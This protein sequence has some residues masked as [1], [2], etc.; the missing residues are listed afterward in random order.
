MSRTAIKITIIALLLHSGSAIASYADSKIELQAKIDSIL[1]RK[2]LQHASLGIFAVNLA[3]D[4]LITHNSRH[5]FTPASNLKLITTGLAI[6]VLGSD[7]QFPTTLAYSGSIQNGILNGDLYIIG[8]GDPTTGSPFQFASPA[9]TLFNE[10]LSIIRKA[11]IQ[12][13]QGDIIADPRF[14]GDNQTTNLTWGLDDLGTFYGATPT[15]L[16]FF[17]NQHNFLIKPAE[18]IG[19][20]PYIAEQRPLTPWMQYLN[21]TS[22]SEKL[23]ANSITYIPSA[24][25]PIAQ[26]VGQFPIDCKAY[27]LH[28]ANY[29]SALT[30]AYQFYKHLQDSGFSIQGSYGDIG[31]DNFIRIAKTDIPLTQYA[32]SLKLSNTS[33]K[34]VTLCVSERKATDNL[35]II[36]STQSPY[37]RSIVTEANHESNNFYT[38]ALLKAF[39]KQ[40]KA[41]CSIENTQAAIRAEFSAM[42]LPTYK[43]AYNY[44]DGCGL[45][46]QNLFSPEFF[47]AFLKAMSL[48][49]EFTYYL[50][51]IPTP[52]SKSTIQGKFSQESAEFRNRIHI[53][54]GSMTGVLCYS[55]YILSPDGDPEK[56]IIFSLMANNIN[57]KLKYVYPSMDAIIKAIATTY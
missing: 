48:D 3:G 32:N 53:K 27:T 50:N 34:P 25:V 51:T 37:L 52:S 23:S 5:Y 35:I 46:R 6:R 45:S 44:C 28:T 8:G 33:D 54:S 1:A 4:T 14:F 38:E 41:T 7:Y 13:I 47:V 24:I 9:P 49:D 2:P 19:D 40:R 30:C 29:F 17:E 57:L 16:N 21:S 18:T 55:G 56:T 20:K 43:S 11:G 22:T 36:G 12:S 15:G 10:W 26:F 31:Y 42:G 39:V